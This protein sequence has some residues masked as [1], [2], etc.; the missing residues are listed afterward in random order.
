M[1]V[2]NTNDGTFIIYNDVPMKVV[3]RTNTE[4]ILVFNGKSYY[5][6]PTTNETKDLFNQLTKE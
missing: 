6:E 3:G 5:V 1:V 2:T 4:L